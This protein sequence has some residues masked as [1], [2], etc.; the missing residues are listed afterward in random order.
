MLLYDCIWF[1]HGRVSLLHHTTL[2]PKLH[3]TEG[4]IIII[5]Y[6]TCIKH[7]FTVLFM[8]DLELYIPTDLKFIMHVFRNPGCREDDT[9]EGTGSE[10]RADVHQHWRASKGR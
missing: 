2:F 9:W 1:V 7:S 6:V 3:N 8:L 4:F 5:N 10:N